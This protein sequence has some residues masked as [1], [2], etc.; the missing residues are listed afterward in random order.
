MI[1]SILSIVSYCILLGIIVQYCVL[2]GIII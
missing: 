2:L 1:M